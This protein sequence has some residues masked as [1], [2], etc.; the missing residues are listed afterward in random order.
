MGDSDVLSILTKALDNFSES[1]EK[2]IE[3]VR[4]QKEEVMNIRNGI[5]NEMQSGQYVRNDSVLILSAPKVI[6][7][8]V[9]INGHLMGGSEVII[10]GNTVSLEATGSTESGG[11]ILSRAASIRNIAVDPGVDGSEN[12]VCTNRSEIVSQATSIVLDSSTD[13]GSFVSFP[14]GATGITLSSETG[15]ALNA[16]PSSEKKSSQIDEELTDLENKITSLK[17]DIK[18]QMT[19]IKSVFSDLQDTMDTQMDINDDEMNLCME[20]NDLRDLKEIFAA[21][22]LTLV[23]SVAT[24]VDM[25]TELA[26]TTRR[27]KDLEEIKKGL[28]ADSDFKTAPTGSSISLNSELINITSIDGDGNLRDGDSAGFNIHAPHVS[29]TAK[30]ATGATM[31]D[32]SFDVT[33]QDI[34]LETP[35]STLDEKQANGDILAAGS[36]KIT[37]KDILIQSIDNEM[38][39]GEVAEKALTKDSKLTL[40]TENVIVSNT[41]T[42]GKST[43]R[44]DLNAKD[45]RIAAY[46]VDKESRADTEMAKGSQ[47][48]ILTEKIFVGSNK[49]KKAAELVQVAGK[50]V[51]VM[52]KETAEM[53]EG[54]A[55]SVLTLNGGNVTAGGS[56]VKLQGN[57]TIEGN[58]DIKGETKSP[59]VTSDQVE[60]KSA[61]KSPN[62]NDTMGA[63]VPGQAGKP[64]AKLTEQEGQ[65]AAASK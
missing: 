43:G 12:V 5:L 50:A 14:G 21:Q 32:S 34:T 44:I 35:E 4:K 51:G 65:A 54:E 22:K 59:K 40:R 8:N 24:Y 37:S 45:I 19:Q 46:D 7:G 49:D 47:T 62:I 58:A 57:T 64:S 52:G 16:T 23:G 13:K 60:V 25:A 30:D 1:V 61:F 38:K 63:G 18:N 28:P 17:E 10:R 3:E 15:I 33:V 6:I 48:Q 11:T 2:E 27:K 9:D 41:D 42:E 36:V 39:E 20:Y 29:I 56:A 26:E 55:K 53:Q 31:K